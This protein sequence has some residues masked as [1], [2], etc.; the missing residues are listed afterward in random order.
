MK[1]LTITLVIIVGN[2]TIAYYF[3]GDIET[4]DSDLTYIILTIFLTITALF[5]IYQIRNG[6]KDILAWIIFGIFALSFNIAQHI[7]ALNDLILDEKPFPSFADIA[8]I[9]GTISLIIFFMLTIGKKKQ[10]ISKN[11]FVKSIIPSCFVITV[12]TY[13]FI[14]NHTELSLDQILLIT[15]PI[16]DSIALTAAFIGIILYFKNKLNLNMFLICVSMI[17]LTTG[18]VLFQITS[19]NNEN[20]SGSIS[21]LFFYIQ[22]ILLT[23]GVYMISHNKINENLS[24][25][26]N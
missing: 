7:W 18:D 4:I 9:V 10:F 12:Y 17:P 5:Q 21:D 26:K 6:R 25:K 16:L 20:Y 19:A 23:F 8:F 14:S 3:G 13:F 22:I 15:Y 2:W 1:F 11:I 24:V